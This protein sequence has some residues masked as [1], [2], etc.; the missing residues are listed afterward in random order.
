MDKQD[1]AFIREFRD[2]LTKYGVTIVAA[3]FYGGHTTLQAQFKGTGK[4]QIDLDVYCDSDSLSEFLE[5]APSIETKGVM[6]YIKANHIKNALLN[7]GKLSK[8]KAERWSI[9]AELF[10]MSQTSANNLCLDHDIEP[11]EVIGDNGVDEVIRT[12]KI[13]QQ[14]NPELKENIESFADFHL[15]M[16]NLIRAY[17]E[18]VK[19]EEIKF[20]IN[21]Y[22]AVQLTE[23]GKK[24]LFRQHVELYKTFR[25]EDYN[26]HE[27]TQPKVDKD[28]YTEYQLWQLMGRFG[29]MYSLGCES[30][31]EINIKLKDK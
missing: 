19:K 3:N 7:V 31:F 8:R 17:P 12:Y 9:V 21:N 22:V 18:G 26:G 15:A 10:D 6:K 29:C 28:G 20:N 14:G 23:L 27:Y 30:P 2:L 24:E 4:D 5:D 13:L 1:I 11:C 16:E 25:G